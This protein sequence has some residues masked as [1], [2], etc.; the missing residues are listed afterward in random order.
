[1]YGCNLPPVY[2]FF[3]V[4]VV[5]LE[6]HES[7]PLAPRLDLLLQSWLWQPSCHSVWGV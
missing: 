6:H 1:M 3:L 7:L 5:A 2:L 4:I